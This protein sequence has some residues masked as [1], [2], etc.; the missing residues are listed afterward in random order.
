M[1]VH[2]KLFCWLMILVLLS[3]CR[4]PERT[5]TSSVEDNIKIYDTDNF[6]GSVVTGDKD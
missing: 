5:N 4:A 1:S 2:K 3:S 6:F